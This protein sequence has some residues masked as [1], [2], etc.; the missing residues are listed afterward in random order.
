MPVENN[1]NAN[2]LRQ[3]VNEFVGYY[4]SLGKSEV[5]LAGY[6]R[7]LDKMADFIAHNYEIQ[8][9]SDVKGY[10]LVAHQTAMGDIKPQSKNYY[11]VVFKQ[12]FRYLQ[13][14]GHIEQDPSNVLKNAKVIHD[15]PESERDVDDGAYAPRQ[16]L[17][18]MKS[19]D[20]KY[21]ARNRAIVALLSGSGLRASEL[22]SMNVGTWRNQQNGHIRIK[23]KG[24][25]WRWVAVAKYVSPYM[26]RHILT[27]EDQTDDAPLFVTSRKQRM[28]RVT[29]YKM[30]R[31]YQ[32]RAKVPVG[33]HIFRHT[34]LT[35]TS[36]ASN[37]GVAK[38]LADHADIK[39]TRGYINSTTEERMDAVNGTSWAEEMG[40]MAGQ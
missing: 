9:A 29:L 3:Y 16:L 11:I 12:F 26:E 38:V 24:G 32:N 5:T 14:A 6:K 25:A 19:I 13:Q 31:E 28:G 27:L 4:L 15:D 22:C 23:R 34:F 7:V 30:L 1:K 33:V 18:L 21:E 40:G 2:I 37:I 8:K 36:K 17:A 39:T 10:M 35:G 20:G